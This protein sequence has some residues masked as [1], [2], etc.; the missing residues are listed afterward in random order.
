[1]KDILY[2]FILRYINIPIEIFSFF[3]TRLSFFR[4]KTEKK[5]DGREM[6]DVM[7]NRQF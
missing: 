2:C 4:K 1:M 3:L 6:G 7:K 5:K